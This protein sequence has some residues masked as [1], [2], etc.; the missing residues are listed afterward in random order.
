MFRMRITKTSSNATAVQVVR[1]ASGKK[2]IVKHIGSAHTAQELAILKE[3]AS[4]WIEKSTHQQALFPPKE[5]QGEFFKNTYRYL[6]FRYA[7]IYDSI[8]QLFHQFQ[9]GE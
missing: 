3:A 5:K 6:G 4:K 1:Y 8:H 9:F 7:L 2:I